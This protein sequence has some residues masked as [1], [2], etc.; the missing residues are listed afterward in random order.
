LEKTKTFAFLKDKFISCDFVSN[1]QMAEKE[2]EIIID[3]VWAEMI[4][5]S[6]YVR[7]F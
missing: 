4:N 5:Y 1:D 3:S 7:T 2:I 6:T